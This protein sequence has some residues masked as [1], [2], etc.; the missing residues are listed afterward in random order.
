[1]AQSEASTVYYGLQFLG[2]YMPDE[3]KADKLFVMRACCVPIDEWTGPML[4][5]ASRIIA[6][7]RQ[8]WVTAG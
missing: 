1:M 6:V 7:H 3:L 2:L 5:E 8:I 4:A